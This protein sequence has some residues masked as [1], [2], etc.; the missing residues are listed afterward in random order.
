VIRRFKERRFLMIQYLNEDEVYRVGM[1]MEE[2]GLEFYTKMAERSENATTKRVF[3]RL[4]R[5]EKEHLKTFEQLELQTAG[6]MGSRPAQ[7]DKEVS[8]Y[9][10]SIVDAGIFRNIDRMQA[11]RRGAFNP[12]KALDLALQVE[13]D[14]VLY[15]T[16]AHASTKR[17]RTREALARL[18]DEE[19]SHVVEITRRL[20][21][22]RK[23]RT[24][25]KQGAP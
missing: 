9:V 20:E 1:C 19:K 18:I 10:C 22:L 5:D 7:E 4:A 11:L 3:R 17:R 2:A 24:K 13:K 25:K 23:R 16:E 14:A 15:Y 21:S 6:S 8:E 12:E